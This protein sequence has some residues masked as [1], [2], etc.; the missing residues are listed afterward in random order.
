MSH[1]SEALRLNKIQSKKGQGQMAETNAISLHLQICI[2]ATLQPQHGSQGLHNSGQARHPD[3]CTAACK[4]LHSEATEQ[5]SSPS[6][7]P[8][9]FQPQ[10][11]KF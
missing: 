8:G 9:L 3:R 11:L 5:Q 10:V 6:A 4:L 1:G 7:L 2:A